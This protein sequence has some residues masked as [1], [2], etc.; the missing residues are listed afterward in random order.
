[1]VILPRM[2][3][4]ETFARPSQTADLSAKSASAPV[5]VVAKNRNKIKK[6]NT[7]EGAATGAPA[8]AMVAPKGPRRITADH[9]DRQTTAEPL[10][11]SAAQCLTPPFIISDELIGELVDKLERAT[12]SVLASAA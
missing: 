11:R 3:G 7:R 1:M 10:A 5:A 8:L 2:L 12:S 6:I 9:P 4:H